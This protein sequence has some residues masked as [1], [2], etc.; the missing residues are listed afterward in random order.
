MR[1]T[2]TLD[3]LRVYRFDLTRSIDPQCH[4]DR[5]IGHTITH[6]GPVVWVLNNPS[7][8]DESIDD[9]TVRRCWGYTTQWGFDSM[10]FVNVNP[11]RSTT[12]EDAQLPVPQAA[13]YNAHHIRK[14]AALS[15][16]V[17]VAWGSKA[18]LELINK[19]RE[20][21]RQ[22]AQHKTFY[23]RLTKSGQP[24]HPLYLPYGLTPIAF[25]P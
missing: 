13:V 1:R 12:P 5:C 25:Q 24:W 23:L 19:T 6:P 8:A 10:V 3:P 2:A 14:W 18:N 15:S 16:I 17:I 4:C 9:P 11:F 21:L 22:N 7:T 20:M